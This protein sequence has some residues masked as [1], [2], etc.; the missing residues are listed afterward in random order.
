MG[1]RATIGLVRR[2]WYDLR[3][4]VD[5]LDGGFGGFTARHIVFQISVQVR[6]LVEIL[7]EVRIEGH[8]QLAEVHRPRE[9]Y[10]GASPATAAFKADPVHGGDELVE[11][12]QLSP[13]RCSGGSCRSSQPGQ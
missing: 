6:N 11:R 5:D 10:V 13:P 3:E 9:S 2:S 4:L 7:R 1:A 12:H 8:Q